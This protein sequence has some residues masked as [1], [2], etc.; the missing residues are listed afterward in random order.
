MEQDELSLEQKRAWSPKDTAAF[1]ETTTN[2]VYRWVREGVIPA[3]YKLGGKTLFDPDEQR[4][5]RERL[6]A[7][8]KVG[9]AA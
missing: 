6:K 2:T 3:P 4:A 7:A 8:R 9:R 1:W 5:A